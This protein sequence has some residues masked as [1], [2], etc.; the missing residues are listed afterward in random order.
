MCHFQR[1]A[2]RTRSTVLV[3]ESDDSGFS[4]HSRESGMRNLLA[5]LYHRV[6][7]LIA[8]VPAPRSASQ[9]TGYVPDSDTT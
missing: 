3:K 1:A 4:W 7:P 2:G 5:Q 9:T 8:V 6:S